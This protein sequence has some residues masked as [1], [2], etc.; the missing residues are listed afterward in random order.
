MSKKMIAFEKE[1]PATIGCTLYITLDINFL[2]FKQFRPSCCHDEG[3]LTGISAHHFYK[4]VAVLISV[5]TTTHY[6]K[7]QESARANGRF[8]F[9]KLHDLHECDLLVDWRTLGAS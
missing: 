6:Y 3:N 7:N 1:W 5:T 8:E 9:L 2:P 4:L